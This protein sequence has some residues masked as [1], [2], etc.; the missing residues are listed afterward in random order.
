MIDE[1]IQSALSYIPAD[2]RETWVSAAMAIR[3]E[4]GDA[5][6]DVWMD[7]SR[8]ADSFR[9]ADARAVWRSCRGRG[10]T[11]GTLFHTARQ[12]G[13]PGEAGHQRRWTPQELAERRRA[14][15]ERAAR[16]G[17]Q[18]EREMQHAAR[19]A[20]WIMHHT[21]QEPHAYL[22]TKGWPEAKGS[23]WY[24]TPDVNLLYIPM[25]VDGRLVGVQLIDRF[26]TKKYLKGQRTSGAE[27]VI[28]NEGRG[29]RDYWCEGYATGLSLRE[30]LKALGLRYRIHIAF[31]AG[32]LVNLATQAGA[33]VVIADRDDSQTGE[34]AAIKTGLPYFLPE[35]GDFNDLHQATSTFRASRVLAAW[36][37]ENP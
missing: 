23:V 12:H 2:D 21:V 8:Q 26:G 14:S 19:R 27:Y 5:G 22:H 30:C 18:R 35:A 10:I 9:E 33:G 36:L 29:V 6:Y 17:Q 31:S 37:K 15:E 3:A 4:V 28:S 1:R 24:P 13:W 11:L 25:R 7:W 16:D 20:A 32:N 34:K